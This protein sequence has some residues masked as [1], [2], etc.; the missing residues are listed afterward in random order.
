MWWSRSPIYSANPH[1]LVT[2]LLRVIHL[3]YILDKT[4]HC[5]SYS[6]AGHICIVN[7]MHRN[8]PCVFANTY[9]TLRETYLCFDVGTQYTRNA[10]SSCY[11]YDQSFCPLCKRTFGD[12]TRTW[13]MMDDAVSIKH[14]HM[15]AFKPRCNE[16]EAV[17]LLSWTILMWPTAYCCRTILCNFWQGMIS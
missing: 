6:Q 4:D 12:M 3:L 14:L 10:S 15:N 9:S 13:R 1:P 17:L 8:C 11:C 16:E 5:S 2:L 7:S